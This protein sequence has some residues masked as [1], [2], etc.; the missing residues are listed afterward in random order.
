MSELKDDAGQGKHRRACKM[1]GVSEVQLT[2]KKC[3]NFRGFLTTTKHIGKACHCKIRERE[4]LNPTMRND[5]E[6]AKSSLASYSRALPRKAYCTFG[7]IP[8]R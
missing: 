4:N 7:S 1:E 5:N 2:E 3:L 8:R 6:K